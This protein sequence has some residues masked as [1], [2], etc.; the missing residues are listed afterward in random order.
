MLKIVHDQKEELSGPHH[1]VYEG[2][3]GPGLGTPG[4]A[5]SPLTL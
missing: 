1:R 2:S 5:Y 3:R 4:L